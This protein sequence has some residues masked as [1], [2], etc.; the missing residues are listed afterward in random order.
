MQI[1]S[2]ANSQRNGGPETLAA[3]PWKKLARILSLLAFLGLSVRLD[4]HPVSLTSSLI[5][6]EE[7]AI[8]V[9]LELMVED[10]VLYYEMDHDEDF[11]YPIEAL[12]AQAREHEAFLLEHFQLRDGDGDRFEGK[13]VGIDFSELEETGGVHFDDLMAYSIVYTLEYAF[14]QPPE[15]LTVSQEFGG[16]NP[17]VPA[18]MEVSVFQHGTRVDSRVELSHR[19]A[20]T[21]SLDPDAIPDGEP[22]EDLQSARLRREQRETDDLGI[23]SYSAVYSYLY[24]TDTEVRH[25]MLI[26][27]LTLEDWLPLDRDDPDFMSVEEQKAARQGIFEFLKAQ[28]RIVLDGMPVEPVLTR[29]EFFGPGLR[30][31]AR[32]A[33]QE[34]VSVYNA[35]VGVILSFPAP[36]SPRRVVFE[37]DYFDERIPVLRPRVYA[38]EEESHDVLFN[39]FQTTFEWEKDREREPV[40][41][42]SLE[43][44]EPA[45]TLRLPILSLFAVA[46]VVILAGMGIRAGS[47]P[48]RLTC[49]LL[50]AGM[51][52]GGFAARGHYQAVVPHPFAPRPAIGED[53]ADRIFQALHENIYRAFERRVEERIYDALER[54]VAGQLLEDLYLQILRN[55]T[56]EDQGG[57]VSRIDEIDILAGQST[58]LEGSSGASQAFSYRCTWTVTGTVEHWGHIHIRKNRYQAIFDVEGLPSGWKITGFEPL[59]EERVERQIRLRR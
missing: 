37:W 36:E 13:G 33:P 21:F 8:T 48:R 52:A 43:A 28:Q 16:P 3:F 20:H 6:V 32:E 38:F 47:R 10:L 44:P 54:S 59:T 50:A 42:V 14:Q 9:E 35:R 29:L 40:K 31:F 25:E 58:V 15:F 23:T 55:L 27:V 12:R 19:T 46:I 1:N 5:N 22:G 24:I 39:A 34:D 57:A 18:E 26:P 45:P 49:L 51:A 17:P 53:E 11:V 7:K 4:A 2:R 56:V 41:L 30:D